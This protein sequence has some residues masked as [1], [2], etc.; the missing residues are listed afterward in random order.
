MKLSNT[1]AV[2]NTL[3]TICAVL[4]AFQSV[5]PGE[6][7]AYLQVP[8]SRNYH[9]SQ[10]PW[11][12]NPVGMAPMEDCLHCLNQNRG[13]CSVKQNGAHDYDQWLDWKGNPMPWKSQETYQVGGTINDTFGSIKTSR[14]IFNCE[15]VR[16]RMEKAPP[17][18][19]NA[20]NSTH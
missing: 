8:A 3:A 18:Q 17:P 1:S 6:G 20:L 15:D 12:P 4:A 10:S 13:V 16:W 11:Y 7:Y 19:K 5:T 14:G 2:L 9:A